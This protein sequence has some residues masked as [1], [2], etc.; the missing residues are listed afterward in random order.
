MGEDYLVILEESKTSLNEVSEYALS[1][2]KEN[3]LPLQTQESKNIKDV[4]AA[5]TK[6]VNAFRTEFQQSC[7]YHIETSSDEIIDQAY[8]TIADYYGRANELDEEAKDLNNLET[9]FDIQ[10]STYKQLKDCRSELVSLKYMWDLIAL[11]DLQF[12]SW[13]KTLWDKIETDSLTQLI[14]DMQTKQTNPGQP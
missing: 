2:V 1:T 9:L 8:L 12:A 14:K 7:P 6:K 13:K 5:F 11:V 10:K 4:L 3:I